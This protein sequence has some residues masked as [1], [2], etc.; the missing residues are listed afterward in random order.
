[1]NAVEKL[2]QGFE[3]PDR[4]FSPVPFWFINDRPSPEETERQ[5]KDFIAHGVHAV[6]LHPRMGIPEDIPYLSEAFMVHMTCAVRIAARLGMRVMLYDEGM[7]PSGSAGG[8][9]AKEDPRY[10][11][12]AI[13]LRPGDYMPGGLEEIVLRKCARFTGDRIETET[14]ADYGGGP[15]PEGWRSFAIA[16]IPSGGTI[17]G[18]HFGTDSGEPGAPPAGDILNPDAVACFIRLTHERYHAALKEHFGNTVMAVF[19]D[20]PS[21]MGRYPIKGARPYTWGFGEWLAKRGFDTGKLPLL[22]FEGDGAEEARGRYARLVSQ[23]LLEVFYRPLYEWC[24]TRGVALAGHPMESDDVSAYRF[25]HIPGQDV[26]FRHVCP[27]G[28]T[29]GSAHGVMAKAAADIARQLKRKRNLNEAL[30]CCYRDNDPWDMPFSDAKWILDYLFARGCNMVVPHAFYYSVD[31]PGRYS[32]RPPDVGPNSV[33][34]PHYRKISAYIARMCW[35]NTGEYLP[36]VYVPCSDGSVPAT[37]VK[38]LYETQRGFAY[39][40][41]EIGPAAGPVYNGDAKSIPRDLETDRPVPALRVRRMRMEGA[42]Y[43]MLFNE[44]EKELEFRVSEKTGKQ[45]ELWFPWQA[46]RYKAIA[47]DGFAKIRLEARQSAVLVPV[48]TTGLSPA[49]AFLAYE[50]WWDETPIRTFPLQEEDA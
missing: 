50:P 7:Y 25:M 20:E 43:F 47:G 29:L 49:P 45:Y 17:R 2:Q 12:R 38:P 37:L 26:V 21:P 34:W 31:G 10:A 41:P 13:V 8:L 5:L 11:A 42:E 1:M 32:E 35:L 46:E 3:N 15:L 24:D 6:V 33:W 22:W 39:Y 40:D 30:G 44:G 48:E 28:D 19:T 27:E 23:R 18:V 4:D 14:L 36:Q 16:H 9:V